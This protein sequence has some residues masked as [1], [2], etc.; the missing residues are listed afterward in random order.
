M[1]NFI[2]PAALVFLAGCATSSGPVPI[3]KDT[4]M[5]AI[6]GRSLSEAG[7]LKTNAFKEAGQFCAS[8]GKQFQVVNTHQRELVVMGSPASAEIQFMCLSDTDAELQRPKLKPA[9]TTVI[10]IK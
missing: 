9:P 1:K 6:G 8:M 3:G 4:Y 5:I 10:E 7:T 2:G